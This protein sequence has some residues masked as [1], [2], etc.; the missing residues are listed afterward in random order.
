M[1]IKL[2]GE[3]IAGYGCFGNKTFPEFEW[4]EPPE[5]FRDQHGNFLY[6]WDGKKPVP[7]DIILTDEQKAKER[8]QKIEA[9]VPYTFGQE[10]A[11]INKAIENG[12]E[13]EEYV[14]YR[15]TMQKLKKKYPK[16]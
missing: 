12:I 13:D 4:K 5:N 8:S 16:E 10:L 15:K 6:L 3:Y 2:S 9:E 14:E 1:R 11:L 7:V